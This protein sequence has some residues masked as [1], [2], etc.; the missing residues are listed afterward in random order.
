M[1][2]SIELSDMRS[3]VTRRQA[4][5]L[6]ALGAV[7]ALCGL[8]TFAAPAAAATA[9][10]GPPLRLVPASKAIRMWYRTPG[11]AKKIIEEGLTIG[12]GRIGALV[13]GDPALDTLYISDA[14][15]WTG[16]LNDTVTSGGQLPYG[17]DD[18]GS[19]TMLGISTVIVEGHDFDAVTGYSREL[20]LSNG[21]VR[22]RYEKG[23]V[24]Y[25]RVVYASHPDDAIVMH[26]TQSGGGSYTG[27]LALNGTHDETSTAAGHEVR[28][29]GSF[30]NGLRYAAAGRVL[31]EG[32]AVRVEGGEV[33]FENCTSVII[34]ISGGTNYRPV[35]ETQFKDPKAKPLKIA[36]QRLT[37]VERQGAQKT[38]A[39]HV[40]DHRELFESQTVNL[41]R[42]SDAQRAMDTWERMK[43]RDDFSSAPDPELE[44]SY[45]QFGRYLTIAGSR[46]SLPINLQG[47]WLESNDPAWMA[48][49]H[50][51]INIQ[52]NYWLTDRA[53]L[54]ECFDALT[55]YCLSQLSSWEHTTQTLFQDSR[56]GFRNTSGKV[57]GWTIAISTNI[58]GG[59][60]WWWNPTGSAW[61]TNT[62]FDHFDF[63][64]DAEFLDRIW[65]LLKGACEFWEARLITTTV[66]DPDGTSREV[67]I[68]DHDWS[69]EH[70]PTNA[71]GITYAQ[72]LVWQL[73]ANLQTASRV[74]GR[75][76][77]YAATIKGLQERLHL[78]RVSKKTGWLQEWMT[79]D[80]L[81]DTT[82]RH[83]SP[84]VG[85]FP[86]DRINTDDSPKEIID[87]VRNMLI[88]RGMD[89]YG[90]AVAWRSLCWARLKNANRAYRTVLNVLKP[91]VN[92]S[93]G[94]G[95]NFLD[96]YSF[97]SYSV[98]QIDANLGTPTAMLEMLVY[99]RPGVIELLPAL[100][101]AWS[102]GKVTQVGARGGFTVDVE[103]SGRQVVRATVTSVG[104]TGTEVRYGTW[105][106]QVTLAAGESI[107][108]TPPAREWVDE[109]EAPV[110][111]LVNR[112]SGKAMDVPNSSTTPGTKL[113]QWSKSTAVNQ[114]WST[115]DLGDGKVYLTSMASKLLAEIGGGV[116]TPGAYVTQWSNS[117]GDSQMWRFVDAG[118]GYTKIV[119]VRS[120]L[121]LSVEGQST[122]D[123][124]K[125]VQLA[126]TQHPSQQWKVTRVG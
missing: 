26:L 70:G 94:S 118:D 32:G 40:N 92:F 63:T 28:F 10:K 33:V 122:A 29:E 84:L 106:Q 117:G 17:R 54:G 21:V 15:M 47:P 126:D 76:P 116:T 9:A 23:G 41:G 86:G 42:S 67:L 97:G 114:K 20:D 104:G 22:A 93:N 19:A 25:E 30:A 16:G 88:A 51:D 35:P 61:L 12:N 74:L 65:P 85:V 79:D 45:L 113:I 120:G 77:E 99:S 18:F 89:S 96:L 43:A 82:H 11:D 4:M 124:A 83:L 62:L 50:T 13:T 91:S 110:Y 38:L 115:T 107:T 109:P 36:Q 46:D 108:V 14:T 34:A 123:G 31:V 2:D 119:N 39:K 87:G 7:V 103:W 3:G 55:R 78:P 71:R 69:A 68:D 6:G 48:D 95:R 59:G 64:Q 53:R 81:G 73:F 37:H 72:E 105:K 8:P 100:P 5:G 57:A 90:W 58:Y 1:T 125:L 24:T 102:D 121:L 75:E 27:R 56:N 60:G 49:Y 101:A 111:Q 52:M 98:F 80:N 44:A 66:T 112:A